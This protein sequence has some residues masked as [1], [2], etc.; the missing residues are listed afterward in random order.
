MNLTELA[1]QVAE[2]FRCAEHADPGDGTA[3][4]DIELV[5]FALESVFTDAT[6]AEQVDRARFTQA[7]AS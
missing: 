6:L 4:H 5:Q 3:D 7:V 2:A 1:R